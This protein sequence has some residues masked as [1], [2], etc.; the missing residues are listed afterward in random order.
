MST[1]VAHV[2]Y[3]EAT[4]ERT[5]AAVLLEVDPVGLVRGR[6]GTA[7]EGF[8]LGQQV[9]DRPYAASSLLVGALKIVFRTAMAGICKAE[10]EAVTEA[11][12]LEIHIPHC[13]PTRCDARGPARGR[14]V[15]SC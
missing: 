5:T 15:P 2:F 7:A 9:N 13:G 3:P 8:T 11:L 4:D 12:P 10:P 6:K 1:G 14:R